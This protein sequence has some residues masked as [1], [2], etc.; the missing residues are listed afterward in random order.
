MI[1]GVIYL[2]TLVLIVTTR[3]SATIIYLPALPTKPACLPA[4]TSTNSPKK[5][6]YI[7]PTRDFKRVQLLQICDN[8]FL[9]CHLQR[10]FRPVA[11]QLQQQELLILCHDVGTL[12]RGPALNWHDSALYYL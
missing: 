3:L 2:V 1:R 7:G 11:P 10:K 6:A 12:H 4:K 9:N 5:S 8:K